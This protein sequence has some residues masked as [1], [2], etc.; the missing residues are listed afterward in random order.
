[1]HIDISGKLSG[2][3]EIKEYMIVQLD[4]FTKYVHLHHA[5]SLDNN[6]CIEALKSDQV[7]SFASNDFKQ[8]CSFQKLD[9]HLIAMGAS[10]ANGQVAFLL[11]T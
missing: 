4:A 11:N 1:M 3:S 5:L 2:E 8:F 9:L 7:T 6:S 10:R